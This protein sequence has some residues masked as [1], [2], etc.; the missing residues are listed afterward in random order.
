[1]FLI[2]KDAFFNMCLTST[3]VK[4]LLVAAYIKIPSGFT[5]LNIRPIVFNGEEFVMKL[6]SS[7]RS[8][9]TRFVCHIVEPPY[10]YS[11]NCILLCF[12]EICVCENN[13]NYSNSKLF[14]N[15]ME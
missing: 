13:T 12:S 11:N 8:R 10:R 5:V 7:M 3:D 6:V 14:K 1:M 15:S 2:I 4:C 9:L